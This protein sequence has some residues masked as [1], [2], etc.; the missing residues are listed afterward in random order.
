MEF[1]NEY[2]ITLVTTIIF[3]TAIELIAPDNSMKKYIKFVLGLILVAILITPI[4]S[5]F[6]K[7][8]V[9]ILAQIDKFANE[10]TSVANQ[11]EYKDQKNK[12]NEEVKKN[13]NKNTQKLLCDEFKGYSFDVDIDCDIDYDKVTYK[14]NSIK[15]G[16]Q[17]E[18]VKIIEDVKIGNSTEVTS[19]SKDVEGASEIIS[20][21]SDSFKVDKEKIS[22]YSLD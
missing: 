14:V 6:T 1:I 9:E 16:A 11:N 17:K 22:L 4:I 12:R 2:I 21:L 15:V 10:T 5:I 13:I 19:N 3:L 8:E 18:G 7:G 20:F